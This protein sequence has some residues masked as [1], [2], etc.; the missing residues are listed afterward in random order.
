MTQAHRIRQFVLDHFIAPARAGGRSEVVVR[1]G[2]VHRATGL[3]NAM[4]AVCS[5]CLRF[6]GMRSLREH[7]TALVVSDCPQRVVRSRWRWS[8][9]LALFKAMCELD[10]DEHHPVFRDNALRR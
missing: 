1:A 4:P 5:A 3:A 7:T 9:S 10:L 8:C 2:D 6:R